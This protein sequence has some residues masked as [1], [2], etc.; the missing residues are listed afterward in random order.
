MEHISNNHEEHFSQHENSHKLYD[1]KEN[2]LLSLKKSQW[3]L[4]H[5][6]DQS[7][8]REGEPLYTKY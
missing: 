1:E 7:F 2:P 8:P 5:L 4:G 6:N 3:K